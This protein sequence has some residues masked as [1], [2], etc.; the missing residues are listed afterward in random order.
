[1]AKTA[2]ANEPSMEEILASIRRIISDEEG[3]LGP[4]PVIRT[5]PRRLE[6]EPAPEAN[7][8][9]AEPVETASAAEAE[10]GFDAPAPEPE[11]EAFQ[12]AEAAAE[13]EAAL[14]ADPE[15]Q[16]GPELEAEAEPLQAPP[17]DSEAASPSK[18]AAGASQLLSPGPD[19]LVTAAFNQLANTILASQARTLEDLVQDMLR[20]MLRGWLDDNLPPMVERLVREEIE[21][22]SRGKRR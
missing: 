15:P 12:A 7:W 5:P 4:A 14:E 1:M 13:P 16:A 20:P 8:E 11:Y 21:R 2:Q 3:A 19:A 10:A 18:P 17:Y 6:A 22:V 9:P